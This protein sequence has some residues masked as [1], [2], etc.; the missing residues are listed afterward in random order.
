MQTGAVQARAGRGLYRVQEVAAAINMQLPHGEL[1][2]IGAWPG[3][4]GG[5]GLPWTRGMAV[6]AV[7]PPG[8][9]MLG[10][11]GLSSPP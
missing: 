3:P 7:P 6:L 4:G 10:V 2:S 9:V 11:G 1:E 8:Q 5:Q